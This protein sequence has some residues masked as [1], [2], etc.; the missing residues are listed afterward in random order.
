[1]DTQTGLVNVYYQQS[2]IYEK[3]CSRLI[4]MLIIKLDQQQKM[5]G[6]LA[7]SNDR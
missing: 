7:I 6:L 3:G 4:S 2:R 5:A 1:M